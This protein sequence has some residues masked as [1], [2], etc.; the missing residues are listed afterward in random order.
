[1]GCRGVFLLHSND[2]ILKMLL[3]FKISLEAIKILAKLSVINEIL[4]LVK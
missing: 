3:Y 4:C 1:M 2:N